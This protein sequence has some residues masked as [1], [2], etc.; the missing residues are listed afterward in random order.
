MYELYLKHRN[1]IIE[2]SNAQV[3]FYGFLTNNCVLR[4]CFYFVL[5]YTLA[6]T[7]HPKNKEN[8]FLW[9]KAGWCGAV[10]FQAL[11]IK[12]TRTDCEILNRTSAQPVPVCR[13]LS[14]CVKSRQLIQVPLAQRYCH[15]LPPS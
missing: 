15:I 6:E 13:E 10:D 11:L 4:N 7:Q 8:V 2:N 5:Y 1:G 14:L 9:G 3:L 12:Q